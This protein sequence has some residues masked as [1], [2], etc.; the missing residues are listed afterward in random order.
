MKKK[1]NNQTIKCD[2]ESCKYNDEEG[3]CELEEIQVGCD[4]DNDKC[5]CSE[6]TVCQSFEENENKTSSDDKEETE[7]EN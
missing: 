4:C 6:E 7:E 2:V 1:D 5:A 3:T